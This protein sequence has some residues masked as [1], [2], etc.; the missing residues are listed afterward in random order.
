MVAQAGWRRIAGISGKIKRIERDLCHYVDLLAW[1]HT[2]PPL[3]KKNVKDSD[4][5]SRLDRFG[6]AASFPEVE[7]HYLVQNM[8]E[9][10]S[11]LPLTWQELK[12][13]AEISGRSFS[14]W[15][16]R[17]LHKLAGIYGAGLSRYKGVQCN[18]P[19]LKEE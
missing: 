11:E 17:L 16:L 6:S 1:W 2:Y 12:A 10:V 9:A 4:Y 15:E 8:F 18:A 13:Y 5:R 7:L 3:P 19:V 14:P